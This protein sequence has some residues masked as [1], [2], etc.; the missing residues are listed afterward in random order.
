M[1]GTKAD[2]ATPSSEDKPTTTPPQGGDAKGKGKGPVRWLY[3]YCLKW[4]GTPYAVPALC[5]MSF[6]EASFFPIPPDVL[7]LPMCFEKPKKSF[8][9]ATYCLIASVLGGLLGYYIGTALWGQ[10]SHWFIPKL[11]SQAKFDAMKAS[12]TGAAFWIIAGKGLTPI[13][14][15]V[16]TITAGVAEIP[17]SVF[18]PAAIVCRAIRFHAE[19]TLIFFFGNTVR[20]F[21]EKYLTWVFLLALV[22]LVGGFLVFKH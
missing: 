6:A 16:V 5:V 8:H 18:I 4:A 13:P 21:I 15:K 22:L 17:L 14:F 2:D 19:A 12:Y 9:Y 11:F 3:D 7:L 10:V 1:S 20:P